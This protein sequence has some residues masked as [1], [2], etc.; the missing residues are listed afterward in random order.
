M[1]IIYFLFNYFVVKL[2]LNHYQF[3]LREYWL[4]KEA[5][6]VEYITFYIIFTMVI[7]GG[8]FLQLPLALLACIVFNK[9]IGFGSYFLSRVIYNFV[10]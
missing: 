7:F 1:L 8:T 3:N 2:L 10:I 6:E 9:K 5:Q 4:V